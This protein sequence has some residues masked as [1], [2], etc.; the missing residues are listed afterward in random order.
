MSDIIEIVGTITETDIRTKVNPEFVRPDDNRIIIG[1]N[2]KIA[3]ELNWKP[4]ISL[5]DNLRD[6]VAEMEAVSNE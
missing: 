4:E 3:K 1:S 6:M 2:D 5:E